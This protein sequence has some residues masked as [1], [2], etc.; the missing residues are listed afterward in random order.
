MTVLTLPK[1]SPPCKFLL[2][3]LQAIGIGA[4]VGTVSSVKECLGPQP[5]IIDSRVNITSKPSF[6]TW[7]ATSARPLPTTG[8]AAVGATITKGVE[9]EGVKINSDFFVWLLSLGIIILR[10]IHA[11]VCNNN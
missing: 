11:V 8:W 3:T 9:G 5:A 4:Q 10:F 7:A 2:N 6:A 1:D